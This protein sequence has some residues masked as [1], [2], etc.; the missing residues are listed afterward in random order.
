LRKALVPTNEEGLASFIKTTEI[1]VASPLKMAQ[2]TER[3][4]N[5]SDIK[6]LVIDEADKMFEMGFLEQVD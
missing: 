5:I 3:F 1:L 6:F 4:P 2:L